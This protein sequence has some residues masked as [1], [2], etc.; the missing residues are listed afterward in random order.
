MVAT[1]L[2]PRPERSLPVADNR[3]SD[4]LA[5]ILRPAVAPA[6]PIC[7]VYVEER[8]AN[9]DCHALRSISEQFAVALRSAPRPRI[10]VDLQEAAIFGTALINIL[11]QTAHQVRS[12]GGKLV[13]VGPRTLPREVLR[14]TRLEPLW[15]VFETPEAALAAL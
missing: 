10:I 15:P 14:I 13:L 9:F 8:S 12:R 2:Q 3:F 11:L 4:P 7:F 5:D 6:A 1:T